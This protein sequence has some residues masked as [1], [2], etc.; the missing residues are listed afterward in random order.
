MFVAENKIL[1]SLQACEPEVVLAFPDASLAEDKCKAIKV[2][3]DLYERQ[4]VGVVDWAK[5]IPGKAFFRLNE[6]C[7]KLQGNGKVLVL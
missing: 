4:L 1:N 2:L 6:L 5:Q 7:H 3:S